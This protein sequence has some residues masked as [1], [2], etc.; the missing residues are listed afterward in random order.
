M[1]AKYKILQV[2]FLDHGLTLSSASEEELYQDIA[3]ISFGIL[4]EEDEN[5]YYVVNSIFNN[6]ES[7]DTKKVLKSAVTEIKELGEIEL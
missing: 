3:C 6:N 2:S 4:Y 7:R 1:P 5:Y